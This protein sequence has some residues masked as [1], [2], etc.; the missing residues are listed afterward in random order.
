MNLLEELAGGAVLSPGMEVDCH[1]ARKDC[2]RCVRCLTGVFAGRL[3]EGRGIRVDVEGLHGRPRERE[4]RDRG[5]ISVV[6]FVVYGHRTGRRSPRQSRGWPSRYG[7]R[8][9]KLELV[10]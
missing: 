1:R 8:R 6:H 7:R 5:Q 2:S 3:G 9:R 10:Q 4:Q